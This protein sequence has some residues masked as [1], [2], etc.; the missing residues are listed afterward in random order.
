LADFVYL[1]FDLADK[2][3]NPVLMLSDSSI[4][5]RKITALID[6]HERLGIK[7]TASKKPFYPKIR[8]K[9]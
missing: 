7:R 4:V 2:Y 5:G 8:Y 6:L 3:R 9:K 1:G